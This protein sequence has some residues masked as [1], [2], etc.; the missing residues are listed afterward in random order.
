MWNVHEDQILICHLFLSPF[1]SRSTDLWPWRRKASRPGT[2]RCP[3]SQRRAKRPKITWTTS[4]R[5]WWTR[6]AH[7][8]RP[9]CPATCHPSPPFR[10]LATCWPPPH[11]CTPPRASPSPRTTLPVWS[12]PWVRAPRGAPLLNPQ[13][14]H[15]RTFRY[16]CC[17]ASIS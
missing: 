3:A 15:H 5:A 14:R 9:L 7:S 11:P 1:E 10:T 4:P 6:P 13:P 2:G 12:Q 8:A 17:P 16:L